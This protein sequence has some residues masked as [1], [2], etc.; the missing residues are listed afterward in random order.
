MGSGTQMIQVQ[1]PA[2]TGGHN[3]GGRSCQARV[4][5][6]DLRFHA[7]GMGRVMHGLAGWGRR[8]IVKVV[9]QH[10]DSQTIESL[11]QCL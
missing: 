5:P 6:A 10:A 1:L 8:G 3:E 2:F 9:I 4:R 7:Q 11:R